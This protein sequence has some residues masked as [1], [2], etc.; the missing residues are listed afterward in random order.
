MQ[1]GTFQGLW[2]IFPWTGNERHVPVT[3]DDLLNLLTCEDLAR[4]PLTETLSE[5]VQKR[6]AEIGKI[7]V[8]P[9]ILFESVGIVQKFK[10]VIGKG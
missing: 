6:I 5:Q 8:E 9:S 4:P 1:S 10:F 2:S 7:S 3:K